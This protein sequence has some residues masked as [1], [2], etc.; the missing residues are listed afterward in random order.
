MSFWAQGW[1]PISSIHSFFL[2]VVFAHSSKF[3]EFNYSYVQAIKFSF[4]DLIRGMFLFNEFG[5]V[6]YDNR[7]TVTIIPSC[8]SN[9]FARPTLKLSVQVRILIDARFSAQLVSPKFGRAIFFLRSN[10]KLIIS[11]DRD[12]NA[13]L[14]LLI[15]R[16]ITESPGFALCSF[17][18]KQ[19]R[20]TA[21]PADKHEYFQYNFKYNAH[22]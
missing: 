2:R 9:L 13:N 10:E 21:R 19:G 17:G 5:K 18:A 12:A 20:K 8:I 4:P 16:K 14:S 3:F 11:R 7:E 15:S 22:R 1:P 6:C